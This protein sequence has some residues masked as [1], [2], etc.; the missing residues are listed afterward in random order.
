[1][2]Y[3][4][5]RWWEY[6]FGRTPG[7]K[8]EA[9]A[10]HDGNQTSYQFHSLEAILT[11]VEE[12]IRGLVPKLKLVRVWIPV[13][14]TPYGLP[15]PLSPYLFA[16]AY[17]TSNAGSGGTSGSF[18][19]TVT[20]SD[21]IIF[22][23][24][25]GDQTSAYTVQSCTYNSVSLSLYTGQNTRSGFAQYGQTIFG[26]PGCATG[27]N[28]FAYNSG[29]VDDVR[30]MVASYSGVEPTGQPD[31]TGQAAA[32]S[33]S[34]GE[35]QAVTVVADQSWIIYSAYNN[36]GNIVISSGATKRQSPP[37]RTDGWM[38]DSNAG[39]S[40]GSNSATWTWNSSSNWGTQAVSFAPVAG[41]GARL[42][43]LLGVGT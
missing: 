30:F 16:I 14:H 5:F 42:L 36:A 3:K 34:T 33:S 32:G 1:M 20:G 18:S 22:G 21:P 7:I 2:V 35:T 23:V 38:G 19:Y 31:A 27:S 13:L 17:D 25:N 15:M 43:Q 37:A 24:G 41:G 11:H 10:S 39:V 8:R 28:T 12:R 26:L 6:W 40:T 29:A 9:S 4:F